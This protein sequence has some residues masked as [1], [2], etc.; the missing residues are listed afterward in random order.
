[1]TKQKSSA[2]FRFSGVTGEYAPPEGYYC[3]EREPEAF[4]RFDAEFPPKEKLRLP[5]QLF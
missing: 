2:R 4:A 3:A 1:M 5:G